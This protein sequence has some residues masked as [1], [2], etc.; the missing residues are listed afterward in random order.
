MAQGLGKNIETLAYEVEQD[1]QAAIEGIA[2]AAYSKIV[3][4][5]QEKLNSTRVDYLNALS[6][7]K[8]GELDYIISLK[9]DGIVNALE[10]GAPGYN[11]TDKLLKSQARVSAGPRVGQPWV[12]QGKNGKYA[13]VPNQHRP[14]AKNSKSS[15]LKLVLEKVTVFNAQGL[16]QSILKT[17]KDASGKIIEGKAAV[18]KG[19]VSNLFNLTKYQYIHGSETNQRVSSLYYTFRTTS[20]NGTAWW[21]PGFKGLHLF[22][23]AEKWVEAEIQRVLA[24]L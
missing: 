14:Y 17:F 15:S 24:S 22:A 13:H 12:Q 23:E 2:N 18:A 8:I 19:P 16:R 1:L 7:D 20:E 4:G 21:H 10:V 5:A 9:D 6:F 11:L 3:M